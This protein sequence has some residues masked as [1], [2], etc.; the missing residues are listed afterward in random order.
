M[1]LVTMNKAK[2]LLCLSYIAAVTVEELERCRVDIQAQL[3]DMKPGFTLLVDLTHLASMG[4]ECMAEIGR[5]MELIDQRAAGL[6]V[7]VIPD[8]YKDIGMNIL[9]IFHY[10]HH[11]RIVTCDDMVQAARVI[12]F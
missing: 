3:A 7:R 6:V 2:Q 1:V 9:T 5:N 11:P 10:P 4:I 12:A 8:P